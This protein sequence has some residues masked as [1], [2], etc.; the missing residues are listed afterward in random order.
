[1][2]TNGT[3]SSRPILITRFSSFG[4]II[5][6]EPVT[7]ALRRSYPDAE[8]HYITKPQYLD[9]IENFREVDRVIPY[10]SE[11]GFAG[12]IRTAVRL[13]RESYQLVV[14]LHGSVRSAVV[15]ILVSAE[16]TRKI[17]KRSLRRF[18]LVKFGIGKGR[19]WP[20]AVEKYLECLPQNDETGDLLRPS[21]EVGRSAQTDAEKM[22]LGE[23][24]STHKIDL[25][26]RPYVALAPGAR[27]PTKMWPW[28]RYAELGKRL[29]GETGKNI[30]ILG[31]SDDRELCD[32]IARHIGG[33]AT[34]VAGRTTFSEAGAALARSGLLATNDSGLM[35]MAAA[36]GTPVLAIFGPTSRELGFYPPIDSSSV[37]ETDLPCRPCTTIGRSGCPI[38]THDCMIKITVDQAMGKALRLLEGRSTVTA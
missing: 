5:L 28:E 37:I 23:D 22:I 24:F 10:E 35:H 30:I 3:S 38:S 6:T 2:K 11:S 14:D 25:E 21:F 13:R 18:L 1:L 8:I 26:S 34:N 20:T 19:R 27:W 32:R 29:S 12:L 33:K 31:S 36:V 4:D 9:I 17:K 15:R 7:R 16:L